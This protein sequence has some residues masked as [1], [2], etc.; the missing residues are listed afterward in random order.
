MCPPPP[1]STAAAA[2]T[3]SASP[4]APPTDH[5]QQA[6]SSAVLGLL[7]TC[8]ISSSGFQISLVRSV[9]LRTSEI[10]LITWWCWQANKQGANRQA[11]A[12]SAPCLPPAS[13]PALCALVCL[14]FSVCACP[15]PPPAPLP[16]YLHECRLARR[17]LGD[18][19]GQASLH[20]E[21]ELVHG[22]KLLGQGVLQV[23]PATSRRHSTDRSAVRFVRAQSLVCVAGWW[24]AVLT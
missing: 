22:P 5:R 10:D 2:P 3:V 4:Y 6:A 21:H 8:T 24:V 19:D 15:P 7:L 9:A 18:L 12:R 13:C 23:R 1:P 11:V 14:K 20:V 17:P 16:T